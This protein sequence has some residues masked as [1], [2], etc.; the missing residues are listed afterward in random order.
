MKPAK[1]ARV[2]LDAEVSS[3]GQARRFVRRTLLDWTVDESRIEPAQLVATELVANAIVH[4][5]SPPVLSLEALGSELVLRVADRSRK[6]PVTREATT[7]AAG[8][9][10]L[11]IVDAL[12]D[13]WGVDESGTG[14]VVW[15]AFENAFR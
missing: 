7:D 3:L 4:A 11:L 6:L 9:R 5:L 10:G 13:R 15:V 8:G 14:K 12:A 2:Q 1:E